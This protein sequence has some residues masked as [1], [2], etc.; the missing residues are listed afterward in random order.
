MS[1]LWGCNVEKALLTS[2]QGIC[3]FLEKEEEQTHTHNH[4]SKEPV[5]FDGDFSSSRQPM[6]AQ[7]PD[8]DSSQTFRD[9]SMNV[10]WILPETQ[11]ARGQ[12]GWWRGGGLGAMRTPG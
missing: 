8:V 7:S 4:F 12:G 5:D 10:L 9:V 6:A 2:M 3:H 11:T 1:A